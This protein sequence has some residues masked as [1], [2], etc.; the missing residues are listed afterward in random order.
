M[1]K[2]LAC[3]MRAARSPLLAG[4]AK[5]GAGLGTVVEAENGFDVTDELGG[6]IDA[7]FAHAIGRRRRGS[8]GER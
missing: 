1:A 8:D 7:A 2:P 4:D 5:V 6:E 3:A